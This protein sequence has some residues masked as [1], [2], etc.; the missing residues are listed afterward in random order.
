V[1]IQKLT[2]C[3]NNICESCLTY[4]VDCILKSITFVQEEEKYVGCPYCVSNKVEGY[5]LGNSNFDFGMIRKDYM[6]K[7]ESLQA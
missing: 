6:N 5:N 3:G 4:H 2:C 7:T 1:L